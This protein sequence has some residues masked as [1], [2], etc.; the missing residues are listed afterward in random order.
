MKTLIT[1]I[2]ALLSSFSFAGEY[3]VMGGVSIFK[4][5]GNGTYWNNN[6]PYD[7]DMTPEAFA[8]RYDSDKKEGYSWGVQYTHF[9]LVK[10]DAMAVLTDEPYPGGFIPGNSLCTG[11]CAPL[12]R[13][14]M[15]SDAQSI[16]LIGVKHVGNWSFEVGLN[17]YE[18]KTGGDVH[19]PNY[20]LQNGS[21]VSAPGNFD[22]NYPEARY[23]D[24]MPM[25]GIGYRSGPWSIKI[26]EWFM[27]GPGETPPAF[28]EK[29]T[30]TILVGY[31][32]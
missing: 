9:G 15:H 16:A 25:F 21:W 24:V 29:G 2:F 13:W 32:W 18:V 11:P 26:Q 10:M 23:L 1:L 7:K 4:E 14:R 6:Q 12:R 17:L 31:S 20:V 22:Y 28:T 27:P 8:L 5:P 30:T 19:S 3:T